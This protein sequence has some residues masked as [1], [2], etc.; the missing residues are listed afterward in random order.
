VIQLILFLVIGALL[1][2]ALF[3]LARRPAQPEG[4][5]QE[6]LDASR[7]LSSLQMELLPP[8]MVARI[9]ARDDLDYINSS[10]SEEVRA[11]FLAERERIAL[12]W[13][14]YL[15]RNILS[16][17]RF[18]LGS[19]RLHAGLSFSAEVSLAVDF[20]VLLFAC[21]VLEI[22][23]RVRGP[24]GATQIVRATAAGAARV[25]QISESSLGLIRS[26]I[27]PPFDGPPAG[28]RATP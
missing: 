3:F 1:L 11:I 2:F 8:E 26:G 13:V 20:A 9:F 17:R 10:A 16:L 4:G 6:M 22:M 27:A 19:A 18:H 7:A 21:R 24:Y 23:L 15:R 12:S 14:S 28:D 5:A 25:C